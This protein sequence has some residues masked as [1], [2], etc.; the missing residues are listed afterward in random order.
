MA[1]PFEAYIWRFNSSTPRQPSW[2]QFLHGSYH[3]WSDVVR[4]CKFCVRMT[5]G[6]KIS[7]VMYRARSLSLSLDLVTRY[8][9]H[10]LLLF[11]VLNFMGFATV[12]CSLMQLS[13]QWL[14]YYLSWRSY[15]LWV[16]ELC[17][18]L[19]IKIPNAIII[20]S[21]QHKKDMCRF[22]FCNCFV[23]SVY[24][25]ISC[26]TNWNQDHESV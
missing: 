20:R 26:S 13:G 3:R 16:S 2:A 4:K 25:E 5:G 18:T 24:S 22:I 9:N 12:F 19:W 1:W 11:Q 21:A 15:L 8:C 10:Y 6:G 17:T 14:N 7:T 23:Y